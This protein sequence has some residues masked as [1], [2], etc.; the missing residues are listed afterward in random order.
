MNRFLI[1]VLTIFGIAGC[2]N[3][4]APT[5]KQL[6]ALNDA[7]H[8]IIPRF[9]NKT[10]EDERNA[11]QREAE[12]KMAFL[13]KAEDVKYDINKLKIAQLK[14]LP[15]DLKGVKALEEWVNPVLQK[16]ASSKHDS[17]VVAKYLLLTL[18][19][20]VS[21]AA[22]RELYDGSM[23]LLLN[24]MGWCFKVLNMMKTVNMNTQQKVEIIE[25]LTPN[26]NAA[27]LHYNAYGTLL[28]SVWYDVIFP[29]LDKL[30][31]KTVANFRE[32]LL[33][34]YE[35]ILAQKDLMN[36]NMLQCGYED[37]KTLYA[38]GKLIGSE[39]PA[40]HFLWSSDGKYKTLS[41]LK[42]KVVVLDF[43]AT[44]CGPCVGA[45]P[46]V[47]KLQERYKGYPVVIL[48]VTSVQGRHIDRSG[49][50]SKSI[51]CKGDQKKEFRLMKQF[52]KD[53]DM[54]WPVVFTEERVVNPDYGVRGIP[55]ITIIDA[56]GKVRYNKLSPY[57]PPYEEAGKIDALLKEA[58]LKYPKEPME[59]VNYVSW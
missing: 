36:R 21:Y 2:D 10:P 11:K 48:G 30:P 54:T 38:Q 17:A 5:L 34:A 41:D 57:L 14:N 55:H 26:V 7:V 35:Q 44:W 45:F 13:L 27:F 46:N 6:Y 42:G 9:N 18:Q 32:S 20:S 16:F 56:A 53:L 22:Y 43:W 40:L 15:Y 50:K 25:V 59:K 58:G 23:K 3:R 49:E 24:D 19:D 33:G 4:P 31:E 12:E 28:H 52:M 1:L 51:D 37:F 47:R 8:S 39:A 29:D